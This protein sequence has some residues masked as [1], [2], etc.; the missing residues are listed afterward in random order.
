MVQTT[1][2]AYQDKAGGDG[3]QQQ[4]I[5][6]MRNFAFTTNTTTSRTLPTSHTI[7]THFY[8]SFL[9]SFLD[10]IQLLHTMIPLSSLLF[11]CKES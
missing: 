4:S 5:Q 11:G 2:N 6:Q 9:F 7:I 10:P 1:N 3:P 8:F